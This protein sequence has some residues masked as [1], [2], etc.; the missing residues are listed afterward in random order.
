MICS[1]SAKLP[2][3]A[4]LCWVVVSNPLWL[5]LYVENVVAAPAPAFA[6]W[7]L[8][9]GNVLVL[10]VCVSSSPGALARAVRCAV[11]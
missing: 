1:V 10:S 6:V 3:G 9:Y 8:L 4:R 11:E 7:L 2:V 5:R